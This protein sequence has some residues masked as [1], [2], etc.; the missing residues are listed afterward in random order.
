[1]NMSTKSSRVPSNQLLKGWKNYKELY[2]RVFVQSKQ[3]CELLK[4]SGEEY[5]QQGAK[6][7]K[8]FCR[9]L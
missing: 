1:M 3:F 8:I 2:T 9:E 5:F 7:C 6:L 4:K